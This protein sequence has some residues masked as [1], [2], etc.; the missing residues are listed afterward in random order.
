MVK[1]AVV[2]GSNKGIGLGIV[3]SLCKKFDG[4]VYLTSRD[5]GRGEQALELLKKE[6]LN[7]SLHLL[8]IDDKTSVQTLRDYM[9]EKYGGIDILVNNAAIAFKQ[10]ATEPFGVQATVTLKTN[11]W[12]TKQA[13]EILFPIL[14]PGARV[15]NVSSS[16]GFLGN[17]DRAQNK[18]KAA[19]LKKRLAADD[20]EV[21]DLD[22]M[23]KEFESTANAGNHGEHGWHNSTYSASKIG[24]SA[25]SRI[26]QRELAKDASRP[27]IVV[28]H[29]H[30]GYVDTDMTSHKGPLSID[31]GAESSV[32]AALL[33]PNT[34]TRGAY[35]WHDCQ[36]VD[37]ING[38]TP[39]M[40]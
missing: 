20:L 30:P 13:C 8:D 18:E 40:T 17:L 25:L 23:M 34:S 36:I 16:A 21:S 14:K 9:K 1:V 24:L 12:N 39:P 28:N 26:Q 3:R 33:P 11:Y 32:F 27:D 2:T 6:G 22:A 29:V 5:A 19:V 35:I 38:P 37:W 7:P 4:T 10:A 15:V 31:R